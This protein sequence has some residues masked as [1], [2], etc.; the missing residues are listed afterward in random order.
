MK[1][2]RQAAVL[3]F[4]VMLLTGCASSGSN[5]SVKDEAKISI[6]V[7]RADAFKGKKN[8]AIGNFSVTFVTLDIA[9]AVATDPNFFSSDNGYASSSLRATLSGVDDSIF[10]A[11]TDSIYADFKRKLTAAGYTLLE[12]SQLADLKSYSKVKFENSPVHRK[13]RLK[14]ISGAKREDAVF[15]PSGMQIVKSLGKLN[16]LPYVMYDIAGNEKISILNVNYTVNFA[17]FN[18]NTDFSNGYNGSSYSATVS[19]GQ[20]VQAEAKST[21]L[22]MA[23]G[24]ESTFSHPNGELKLI[25]SLSTAKPFGTATDVTSGLDKFANV[26]SSVMGAFSGGSSSTKKINIQADPAKY[27]ALANEALLNINQRFVE[28]MA[29][30]R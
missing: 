17:G 3:L 29:S 25:R 22:I 12:P 18:T 2:I 10:Q 16:V 26:F 11:I 21:S 5:S 27:Q 28:R 4:G 24:L 19:M 20:N 7:E 13:S 30:L 6:E 15:A 8:V 9:S 1:T 23:N 14:F